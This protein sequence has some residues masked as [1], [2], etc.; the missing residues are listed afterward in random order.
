MVHNGCRLWFSVRYHFALLVYDLIFLSPLVPNLSIQIDTNHYLQQ[1][2]ELDRKA[3][4]LEERERDLKAKDERLRQQ[5]QQQ[6][7]QQSGPSVTRNN[8]PP[9]PSWIPIQP[10]F[11]QDVEVEIPHAFQHIVKQMYYIWLFHV[12]LLALNFIGGLAF[13]FSG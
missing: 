8:W 13:L 6:Q 3:R 10:C 7:Q 5:Q 12:V 4:E 2:Q 1:Q 11:Y 9:L